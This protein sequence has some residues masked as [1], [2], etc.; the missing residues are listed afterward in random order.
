MTPLT[1]TTVGLLYGM[2]VV[3]AAAA[4]K[5]NRS[6][7]RGAKEKKKKALVED[8]FEVRYAT[9]STKAQHID[10]WRSDRE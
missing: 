2:V 3:C 7:L 6:F 4:K 8:Y 1:H 9:L 10:I 5:F